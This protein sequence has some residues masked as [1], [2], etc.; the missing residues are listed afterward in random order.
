MDSTYAILNSKDEALI[1]GEMNELAYADKAQHNRILA[2]EKAVQDMRDAFDPQFDR[3]MGAYPQRMIF[4]VCAEESHHGKWN[5]IFTSMFIEA[6]HERG[7]T[8]KDRAG[9]FQ[10][11]YEVFQTVSEQ[12]PIG[13][14]M[15]FDTDFDFTNPVD[16]KAED[17]VFFGDGCSRQGCFSWKELKLCSDCR[18]VKY[19]SREC[20]KKDWKNHKTMCK[21]LAVSRKDTQ[22]L[23]EV[24]QNF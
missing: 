7:F 20:Q 4:A 6:C 11:R 22:K 5:Y 9:N 15:G 18:V 3:K 23:Q 19:C 14:S 2:V 1:H 10:R 8:L 24:I 16:Y 21:A 13:L 12:V 17:G